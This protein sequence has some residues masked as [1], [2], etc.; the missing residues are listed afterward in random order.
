MGWQQRSKRIEKDEKEHTAAV[1][2]CPLLAT[3]AEQRVSLGGRSMASVDTGMQYPRRLF[4]LPAGQ[5]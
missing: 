2:V 1:I 5:C 3:S 4:S